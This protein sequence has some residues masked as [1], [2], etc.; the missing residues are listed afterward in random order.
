MQWHQFCLL[1]FRFQF[2]FALYFVCSIISC[3]YLR[4]FFLSHTFPS[5]LSPSPQNSSSFCFQGIL[6]CARYVKSVLEKR[7]LIQCAYSR[8]GEVSKIHLPP[9]LMLSFWQLDNKP[10]LFL[11]DSRVD[12]CSWKK[13]ASSLIGHFRK[14]VFSLIQNGSWCT[15]FHMEISY[16]LPNQT[17]FQMDRWK[18]VCQGWVVRRPINT[19]LGLQID[20]GL[21][22]FL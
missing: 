4:P 14:A 3:F 11:S 13:R 19:N 2:F 22:S 9:I 6:R 15:I 18:V 21:N 12:F 7:E 5:S 16:C 17:H 8:A 1:F 20:Q 10:K